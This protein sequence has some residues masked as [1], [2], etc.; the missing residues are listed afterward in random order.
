[1]LASCTAPHITMGS[2]MK[3]GLSCELGATSFLLCWLASTRGLLT[4]SSNSSSA[5]SSSGGTTLAVLVELK[6]ELVA[7][8]AGNWLT[9]TARGSATE[10]LR[11]PDLLNVTINKAQLCVTYTKSLCFLLTRCRPVR[12]SLE[13]VS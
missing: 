5:L 9:A 12:R 2:C 11:I 7:G 3:D 6:M 4:G 13:M 8:A 1:M 10:K